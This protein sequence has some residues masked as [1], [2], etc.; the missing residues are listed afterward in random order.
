[1]ESSYKYLAFEIIASIWESLALKANS[2]ERTFPT[3]Y[4]KQLLEK[5]SVNMY[6]WVSWIHLGILRSI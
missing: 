2:E 1:M 4:S 5:K 6:I 3:G